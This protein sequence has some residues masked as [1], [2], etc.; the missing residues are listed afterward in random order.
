MFA[1]TIF[2]WLLHLICTQAGTSKAA[3]LH[4][5]KKKAQPDAKAKKKADKKAKW[6]KQ[7]KNTAKYAAFTPTYFEIFNN[8]FF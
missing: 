4:K 1:N 6:G 7:T 5:K 8:I 2:A 3:A